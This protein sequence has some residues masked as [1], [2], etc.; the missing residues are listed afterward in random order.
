[1]RV[2]TENEFRNRSTVVLAAV[3]AGET[4]R[5]TRNG[6]EVAE[7]RPLAHRQRMTAEELVAQHQR[8]RRVDACEMARE[9][10]DFFGCDNGHRPGRTGG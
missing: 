9:A 5:I 1:M 6:T 8:L 7:L 3:E 2:I 4:Y 10:D